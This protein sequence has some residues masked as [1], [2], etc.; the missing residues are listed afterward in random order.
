MGL[1]ITNHSLLFIVPLHPSLTYSG[2]SFSAQQPP[3]AA[4]LGPPSAHE[5]D[6]G[7]G[8]GRF[9]SRFQSSC[10]LSR[11]SGPR[12]PYLQ[13]V[14]SSAPLQRVSHCVRPGCWS[15]PA[16]RP[17]ETGSDMDTAPANSTAPCPAGTSAQRLS[18]FQPTP[19][20][21]PSPAWTGS[22]AGYNVL[23]AAGPP[24]PVQ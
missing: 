15:S 12:L 6:I 19:T 2:S 7:T 11:C 13:T 22:D 23:P 5:P 1:S 18:S 24:V 17:P 8:Q 10:R 9:L 14:S 21:R 16:A 4:S 3:L 20:K